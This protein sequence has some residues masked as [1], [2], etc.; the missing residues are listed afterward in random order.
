MAFLLGA[1]EWDKFYEM[2]KGKFGWVRV[3][4]GVEYREIVVFN[5]FFLAYVTR[6][7]DVVRHARL[8]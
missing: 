8:V 7:M 5:K 2:S 4:A 1:V 3:V 6:K